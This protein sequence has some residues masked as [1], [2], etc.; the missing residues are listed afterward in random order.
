MSCFFQIKIL[1]RLFTFFILLVSPYFVF[2]NT[3]YISNSG[4]NSNNGLSSQFPF[5]SIEKLNSQSFSAG[6]SILFK[7]VDVFNGMFWLKGSGNSQN[8]IVVDSYGGNVKPVIDGDGYQACILVY[9]DDNIQI[10]NFHKRNSI[11]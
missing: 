4:D 5:K 1:K 6:D 8:P 11:I 9:N 2:C 10:N 7:S 3:Y